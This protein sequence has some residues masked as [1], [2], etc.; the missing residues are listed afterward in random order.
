MRSECPTLGVSICAGDGIKRMNPQGHP[1]HW[2]DGWMF[3]RGEALAVHIYRSGEGFRDNIELKIPAAEWESIVS[4]LAG[5]LPNRSEK[6]ASDAPVRY[7]AE[8]ADA[9]A[10]GYNA[11]IDGEDLVEVVIP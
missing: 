2:S 9:W 7:S 3:C 5:R 11:A 8:Q 1:F 10:S 4:H 6:Q